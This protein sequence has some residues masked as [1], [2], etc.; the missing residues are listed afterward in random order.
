MAKILRAIKPNPG[1]RAKYRKRVESFLDA[2]QRSVLWWIRAAYREHEAQI[3]QDASPRRRKRNPAL[4][5][6]DVMARLLAYWMR[7][8]EEK[9]QS[10]ASEFVNTVANKTMKSYEQAFKAAGL[11]VKMDR[12]RVMNTVVQAL[13]EENVSLIKK[14][15]SQYL[16]DVQEL[17]NRAIAN[18]RDLKTLTDDLH[19]RYDISRKRAGMI[20]RDQTNKATESIRQAESKKLGVMVGI[21]VHVPGKK[22][23]RESHERMNGKPF[24][25]S[26][27]L[28]DYE[29]KKEVLPGQL[30]NCCCVYRDFIPEFGDKVTPE[31]QALLDEAGNE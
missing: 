4:S 2:M 7:R 26:K 25:L 24:L 19:S 29:V 31:I 21:W 1:I 11:T 30:V 5:L 27:G 12:G 18:G 9:A 8:W 20:A 23:S 14:I 15:P 22:Y 10:I 28:Y 17:V 13:I 3:V 16:S 6:N